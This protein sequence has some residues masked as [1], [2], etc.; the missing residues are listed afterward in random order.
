M[1]TTEEVGG[2]GGHKTLACVAVTPP[3]SE[4]KRRTLPA[5]KGTADLPGTPQDAGLPLSPCSSHP[6]SSFLRNCIKMETI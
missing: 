1:R 6:V 5:S 2:R 4:Q 3:V